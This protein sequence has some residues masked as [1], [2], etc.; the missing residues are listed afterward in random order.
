MTRDGIPFTALTLLAGGSRGCD[1][2]A[3]VLR[4]PERLTTDAVVL[5]RHR[6]SDVGPLVAAVN[7][8]AEHL[9]PWM[10]WASRPATVESMRAFVTTAIADFDAGRTFAYVLLDPTEA[11]I[12][13]GAG[14]HTRRG[15]G[16]LE[17]GYW[18][19]RAWTRRG[20]AS[21]AADALTCAA[22]GLDGIRRVEIRCDET[23]AASAG[24]PRRLGFELESVVRRPPDAPGETDR[25]MVWVATSPPARRK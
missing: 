15:P 6:E 17:I 12:V 7:E 4:P 2:H 24:V 21:A 8:S 14:L 16:S 11:T 20:I 22:F 9:R 13:G 3:M 19:H 18:V 23:N 1:H 5:R 10:P 25:E